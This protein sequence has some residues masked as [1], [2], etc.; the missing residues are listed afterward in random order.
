MSTSNELFQRDGYLKFNFDPQ[1]D[2]WAKWALP[3]AQATLTDPRHQQWWRYQKTWFVGVNVLPNDA[4]GS[5]GGGPQ[6]G[7]AAAEF[8]R[9]HLGSNLDDLD[10]A[11]ISGIFPGYPK[12]EVSE[13]EPGF[14]YRLQRDA[15]HVD[16]LL[17]LGD[18]GERYAREF[19][20]YILAIPLNAVSSSASPLVLWEGSHQIMRNRL[21]KLLS[22]LEF[23]EQVNRPVNEE[24]SGA[25]KEAFSRCTRVEI[26][27]QLGEALL[28][29][30]HL[31][32]GT[33]PWQSL[34]AQDQE[35]RLIAFF[36]PQHGDIAKWLVD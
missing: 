20:Q 36:R 12:P 18:E 1:L 28:L 2:E 17:R 29:D 27:L 32:H 7:G 21:Y 25:R 35:G 16:G 11:Q 8:I 14:A 24:Y 19:H 15:A 5:V 26:P 22:G 23:E 4:H 34:D 31:L 3:F 10:A 33:A 9:T 30:R 13:K 6:L